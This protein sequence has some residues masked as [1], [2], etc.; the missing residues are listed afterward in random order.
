MLGRSPLILELTS[1]S[2]LPGGFLLLGVD[3]FLDLG[4]L[5]ELV[6]VV[7]N[8]GDGQRDAE[9]SANGTRLSNESTN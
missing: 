6:K 2:V 1:F 9:D 3:L 4:L 8:D 7:D 5:V